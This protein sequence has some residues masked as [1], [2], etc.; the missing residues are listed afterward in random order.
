[1]DANGFLSLISFLPLTTLIPSVKNALL[2]LFLINSHPMMV[3][4]FIREW[5]F[6]RE[7]H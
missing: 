3:G 6:K 5:A 2:N 4:G 1:M 7:T